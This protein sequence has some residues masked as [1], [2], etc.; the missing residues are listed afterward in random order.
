MDPVVLF[1]RFGAALGAGFLIGLQ[2]EYAKHDEAG[3]RELFAGARTF[4]LV[5]LTGALAGYGALLLRS[6]LVFAAA[7]ALVGALVA[8]GYAVRA[9]R[10][11]VGV[12]TEVAVLVTFFVGALCV[13]DRMA[14]AAAVAVATTALLALKGHTRAFA[15]QLTDEDVEASL[16]LAAISALVLPV[17]PRTPL[18][19]PPL[20]AVTPFKVW[21]MVVFISGISFLG[22]VLIKLVGARRGVGLTGVLGGLVSST[23]VTLSLAQKSKEA[24][25]LARALGLGI[26]LAWAVMFGRV[27]V[28]VGVVH[29]ALLPRVA[30]PIGAG[31]AAAL[32]WAGF[33]ALRKGEKAETEPTS[34]ANPFRLGPAIQFGLLYGF[35][36]VVSKAASMYFGA[37]GVYVSAIAS[38]VADVDA[39]T[40]SMADLSRGRGGLAPQTAARAI[41]LAAMSNTLVKGGLVLTLGGPRLRRLLLP[42]VVAIVVVSVALAFVR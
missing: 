28:E 35:I 30:V 2:R 12:T 40:L 27:L 14:L 5:A 41:V 23:A 25:G 39:I 31:G 22:Y 8:V 4:T 17:L 1:A 38:G 7:L 18:G 9:H 42:A 11:E 10:G 37:A 13:W 3:G 24:E 6:P 16:K 33:L 34:F 21:L 20:D 19:P 26:L 29:A 36:L 15:R 32:A